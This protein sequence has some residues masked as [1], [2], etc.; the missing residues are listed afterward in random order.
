MTISRADCIRHHIIEH[1]D[2]AAK[3]NVPKSTVQCFLKRYK[4]RGTADNRKSSGKPQLLTPRDKRRIV[5]N[6][7]KDRWSTLD[8]LV[9]DASADTGKNVNK[10]TVRKALHSMDFYLP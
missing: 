8:D 3:L 10:V 4:E 5:S 1:I 7:K 9:D 2:R 6:I